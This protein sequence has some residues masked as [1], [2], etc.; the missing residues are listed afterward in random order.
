MRYEVAQQDEPLLGAESQGQARSVVPGEGH[1]YRPVQ[2]R[3]PT[4]RTPARVR[5]SL[6][7]RF[8]SGVL[9]CGR[10]SCRQHFS[11]TLPLA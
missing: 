3:E 11:E 8:P 6:P 7:K 10:E 2:L 5:S 4:L 1:E 9:H